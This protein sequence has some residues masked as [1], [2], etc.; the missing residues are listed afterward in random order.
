VRTNPVF[1]ITLFF[2]VWFT[3]LSAIAWTRG[4]RLAAALLGLIAAVDLAVAFDQLM[5]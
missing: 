2:G 4:R 1:L 5:R 3:V